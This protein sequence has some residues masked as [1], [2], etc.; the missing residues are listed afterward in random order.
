MGSRSS[1]ATE[2]YPGLS[3]TN[4]A[5]VQQALP[6]AIGSPSWG[7]TTQCNLQRTGD[8]VIDLCLEL[9][10]NKLDTS[11]SA[12]PIGSFYPAEA[13]IDK[14]AITIGGVEVESLDKDWLRLYDSTLRPSDKAA[15]YCAG[16]NFDATTIMSPSSSVETLYLSVPFW[17]TR[18]SD[19]ALPIGALNDV[20]RISVT[21]TADPQVLGLDPDQPPQLRMFAS[22]VLLDE[23]MSTKFTEGDLKYTADV[24]QA[25]QFTLRPPAPTHETAFSVDLTL[26]GWIRAIFYVFKSIAEN[27]GHARYVGGAGT[28]EQALQSDSSSM[29]GLGPV[30]TI[31]EV[32]APLHEAALLINGQDNY[33]SLPGKFMNIGHASRFLE[34]LPMPGIYAISLAESPLYG[35]GGFRATR[36]KLQLAGKFK[37]SV[38]TLVPGDLQ[39]GVAIED[40]CQLLVYALQRTSYTI[41]KGRFTLALS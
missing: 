23:T 25:K 14:I 2:F 16:A 32:F 3:M 41:S 26:T 29:T 4:F 1:T 38:P 21:T 19:Q 6:F 33:G 22:Y 39:D 10:V 37:K 11:Y 34:R 8:L 7:Q 13:I 17:F 35:G 24:V 27:V 18:N 5:V 40:N 36:A 30:Q 31:S 15:Q 9:Q 12:L 20:A 28:L